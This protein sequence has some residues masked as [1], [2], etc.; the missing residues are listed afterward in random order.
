MKGKIFLVPF[1]KQGSTEFLFQKAIERISGNNFSE[2]LYIGPT[3]RKIRDAQ[4]T[5]SKLIKSKAFITPHFSTIKQ[6]TSEVFEEYSQ[7]KK[8]LSN[9]IKP[10]LIQKLNPKITIGYAKALGEFIREIKQYRP[11]ITTKELK[12]KILAQLNTKGP[13]GYD[14]VEKQILE[15]IDLFVKYSKILKQNN[16]MD[17]EDITNETIST[18]KDRISI[19]TLLLDGFFYDLTKLDESVVCQMIEKSEKVYAVSFYDSRTPEKYALP[20]EF[21]TFLRGLNILEEEQLPDLPDIRKDPSYYICPSIEEEVETIAS[22]IKQQFIEEKLSL[23]RTIVTFSQLNEYDTLVHRIFNKYGIPHSIYLTKSLSKYQPVI[24]MLE[25][26]RS[27]YSDYP[28]LSTVSVVSSPYFKLFSP[29]TK[30]WV[31]YYSKKGAVIKDVSDWYGFAP[32]TVAI[33]ENER[34]VSLKEK[35]II[36][37]IQEE[38][39]NYIALANKLRKP[40]NTLTGYANMLKQLLFDLKW[41]EELTEHDEATRKIKREFYNALD[42]LENFESDFGRVTYNATDFLRLLEYLLDDYKVIP[43]VQIKGVPILEFLETRALDCNHLF[44]GGLSEDKFPGEPRY[45]PVLPEW[46]KEK[47]GLPSLEKHLARARFHYFRLVNTARTETFLS[48]YNTHDDRLLLPSPFLTGDAKNPPV[49]NIIFTEEQKQRDTGAKDKVDLTSLMAQVNFKNDNQVKAIIEKKFGP[50]RRL[51][52]TMLEQ[53]PRCPYRFYLEKVLELSPLEE[54]RY[55]IEAKMWG[56]VAHSILERLYRNQVVPIERLTLELEKTLTAVLQEEKLPP[57][58]AEVTRRIFLNS[59]PHLVKIEQEMREQG[60]FP[61]NVEQRYIQKI[62]NDI[63]L[64]GRIDRIDGQKNTNL[65][66]ILDYKSGKVTSI[67]ASQ[68]EKGLHLQ[69]PIYAFLVKKQKPK[70]EII[71]AGIYSLA[72]NKVYWI[73]SQKGDLT[74]LIESALQNA[75]RFVYYIRNGIFDLPLAS[76]ADCLY[77]DYRAICPLTLK[78]RTE[79]VQENL[80]SDTPLFSAK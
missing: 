58:W 42:N 75:R 33:L 74:K 37:Q 53:Y 10:L 25:L 18:I 49:F 38:V 40:K 3:P 43:E 79:D 16:W 78:K 55:E 73:S 77:C 70:Y 31:G 11:D 21:L 72:N 52:V 59:T 19:K 76:T 45:D 41:C 26:L 48:Y 67:S 12:T 8:E 20:Q 23:N 27:I 46:L 47:L 6:F 28:R 22:C 17:A 56:T 15:A 30:E 65:V 5:F 68:V 44:F 24:A 57:F 64:S 60:Y 29:M 62:T 4:L 13:F 9:Y 66:R 7:T 51:S 36:A 14:E 71:D 69:L 50:S 61:I 39:N 63:K 1:G 54:P 2:I 35:E 80:Y 32:R 34:E